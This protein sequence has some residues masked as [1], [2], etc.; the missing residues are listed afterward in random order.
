M[1][2]LYSPCDEESNNIVSSNWGLP[3]F[4]L[5]PQCVRPMT[6]FGPHSAVMTSST[7]T[8]TTTIC[9]LAPICRISL[10]QLKLGQL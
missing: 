8:T 5:H 1:Q 7:T 2:N 3:Q 6:G 10:G 9:V 4:V